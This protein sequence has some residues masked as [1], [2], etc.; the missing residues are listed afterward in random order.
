MSALPKA[1]QRQVAEANKIAEQLKKDRVTPPGDEPPPGAAPNKAVNPTPAPNPPEPVPPPPGDGVAPPGAQPEEAWE[2]KYRVL[3]G[4]YNAEVPRLLQANRE[5]TEN[6]RNL[7]GQ[8]TA[9]QGM[10]STL[11]QSRVSAPAAPGG[12]PAAPSKLVK[13][14]EIKNFGPDLYDFIQRTCR[15]LVLPM[16]AQ[17]AAQP[18]QRIEQVVQQVK[19]LDQKVQL[20]DQ[21]KFAAYLDQHV[22]DWQA[23]DSNPE[24]I[25]WLAEEDAFTGRP[26]QELLDQAANR[27]DGPRVATIFKGFQKENATVTPPTPAPAPPAPAPAAPAPSPATPRTLDQL[28][29]PGQTKS[30]PASAP[31]EA[32]K[33][34]Y[35][36][37]EIDDFNRR[38][39]SYVMKGRKVPDALVQEE[40]AILAAANEGRVSG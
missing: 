4:K 31:N 1:V 5:L 13:D 32:Q 11:A 36:R 26:R 16:L 6:M 38:R 20:S 37:A 9:T 22:P 39:M 17:R 12:A 10:V 25:A 18:D 27:F 24:F 2:K 7:Q 34:I 28:V 29:A 14:E 15:E 3:Q 21:Q 35:T 40:R 23:Q 19:T 30:G 8:M 33:R